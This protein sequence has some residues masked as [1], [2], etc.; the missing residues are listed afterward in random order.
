MEPSPRILIVDDQPANVRLLERILEQDGHAEYRSVT[1]P[2]KAEAV[3]REYAPDLVLLDLMMTP[4][5]GLGVMARLRPLVPPGD[6]LPILVLTADTSPDARRRALAAGAKAFLPKPLDNLD[7][8]LRIR[9]LLQTRSLYHQLWRQNQGLEESVRQRTEALREQARLMDLARDAMIVRDLEDRVVY[10]NEG[11][12]RLYG[13]T[14]AEAM[15]RPTGELF[16]RGADP[17]IEESM[18]TGLAQRGE[19]A[20]EVRR[21]RKDGREV[22]VL[23]RR[24]VVVGDDG[25]PRAEFSIHTDVTDRKALEKQLL[26][27]QRLESIGALAGGIAHDLNNMLTPI[28]LGLGMLKGSVHDALSASLLEAMRTSAE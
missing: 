27:A 21:V 11:A 8:L 15:G 26:R 17:A 20:G 1:D 28:L 3:F 2:L 10:W 22:M 13:W 16:A 9:N 4:L 5:D 25:R 19:W 7:V 23:A 14:S 18:R 24:T 12:E 6:Y